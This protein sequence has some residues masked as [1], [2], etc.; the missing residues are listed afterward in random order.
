[1]HAGDVLTA[2]L[3]CEAVPGVGRYM[4]ISVAEGAAGKGLARWR[5]AEA[6]TNSDLSLEVR[7]K[8]RASCRRGYGARRNTRKVDLLKNK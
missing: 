1:M 3:T 6:V 8:R 5:E 4:Y 2:V 7:G